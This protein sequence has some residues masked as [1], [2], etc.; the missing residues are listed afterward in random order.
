MRSAQTVLIW[1]PRIWYLKFRWNI[2]QK[3]DEELRRK[4]CTKGRCIRVFVL[5]TFSMSFWLFEQTYKSECSATSPWATNKRE[6]RG[7]WSMKNKFYRACAHKDRLKCIQLIVNVDNFFRSLNY[8]IHYVYFIIWEKI[9][10]KFLD[11]Q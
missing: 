3:R 10:V 2:W 1:A 4:T 11:T 6:I 5:E 8:E 7:K 9:I